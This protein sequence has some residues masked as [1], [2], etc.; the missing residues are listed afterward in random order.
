MST[1]VVLPD[2]SNCSISLKI[3]T[4]LCVVVGFS[5]HF[6]LMKNTTMVSSWSESDFLEVTVNKDFKDIVIGAQVRI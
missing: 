6:H 2:Y 1:D 3:I 5:E 4:V